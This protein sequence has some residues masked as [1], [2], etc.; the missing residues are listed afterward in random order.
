MGGKVII[1]ASEIKHHNSKL[2]TNY[3]I[4]I[5]KWQSN[6]NIINWFFFFNYSGYA[7]IVFVNR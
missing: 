7:V 1:Q 4:K 3:E 2:K 6:K 5:I